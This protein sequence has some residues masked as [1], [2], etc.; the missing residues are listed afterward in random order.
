MDAVTAK[1]R[2]VHLGNV[3]SYYMSSVFLLSEKELL[4]TSM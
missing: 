4:T 3:L 2:C 1:T